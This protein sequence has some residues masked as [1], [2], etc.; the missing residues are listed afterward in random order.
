MAYLPHS[1]V[2]QD[3]KQV[4]DF[5]EGENHEL[6][7]ELLE[8]YRI[9]TD[10]DTD[11]NLL[12]VMNQAWYIA[13]WCFMQ[14]EPKLLL[15]DRDLKQYLDDANDRDFEDRLYAMVLAYYILK[16]QQ[17][18]PA[19]ISEFLPEIHNIYISS[20]PNYNPFNDIII[21]KISGYLN[22]HKDSGYQTNMY[23]EV[24]GIIPNPDI[25]RAT[26][27]FS[28]KETIKVLRYY[29]NIQQQLAFIK[30]TERAYIDI[31]GMKDITSLDEI[32][33][34]P[35]VKDHYLVSLRS[36]I[37]AGKYL[38]ENY[39]ALPEL[40]ENANDEAVRINEQYKQQIER[41]KLRINTLKA[42]T[43]R[44]NTQNKL[45]YQWQE[46]ADERE[47]EI[48]NLVDENELLKA[49][50]NNQANTITTLKKELTDAQNLAA[51]NA[52][53]KNK[54]LT[55]EVEKLKQQLEE[56][57]NTNQ[58][59]WDIL[60]NVFKDSVSPEDIN[61]IASYISDII[62]CA[63]PSNTVE[64]ISRLT[65]LKREVRENNK[66]TTNIEEL[67]LNKHVDNQV[68]GVANGATGIAVN[69][70]K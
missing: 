60:F 22:S 51:E 42:Q 52:T 12:N 39:T 4:E 25:R 14:K 37:R 64:L 20:W 9:I 56:S 13:K 10:N 31:K 67:V 55:A 6:N 59:E 8:L 40:P 63:S 70:S 23:F 11:T 49:K 28:K 45:D 54:Q 3:K 58:V 62:S 33:C 46:E 68:N 35:G 17:T 15:F 38:P 57:K 1:L 16:R 61:S 19:K 47:K 29:G 43:E 53:G 32:A 44:V 34:Y 26:R 30:R 7:C 69:E 21:D 50:N 18:L 27:D 2:F 24:D 36:E 66:K 41:L 48:D 65:K 5:L